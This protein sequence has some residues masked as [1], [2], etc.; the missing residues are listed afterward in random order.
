VPVGHTPDLNT[1]TC[2]GAE[3]SVNLTREHYQQ[4]CQ[5]AR[6]IEQWNEKINLI[7][8]KD[9]GRI[10][11]YHIIDSLAASPFLPQNARCADIG[12]GAGLPG[13][14]LAI[15]HPDISMLLI[16]S[17]QKKCR[18]LQFALD[19]LQLKNCLFLC[20]RAEELAPLNCDIIISRLTAPLPK[21]LRYAAPHLKTGGTL[22][23]YKSA[24]WE[25]EL[26]AEKKSLARYHFVLQK[27]ITIKL[28]LTGIERH[29]IFL[30]R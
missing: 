24:P 3:L 4:L 19:R 13:I 20:A 22:I 2:A 12:T 5:Y 10:F 16:E 9:T 17:T 18:F 7:S 21:T 1:F 27:H 25:K 8:R 14:P 29:L 11:T 30:T 6:L 26:T 23:L 28:P 15:V